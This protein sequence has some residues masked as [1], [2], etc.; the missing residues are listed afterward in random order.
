VDG[1]A[2]LDLFVPVYPG[3]GPGNFFLYNLGPTGPGEAYRFAE[4]S[5]D[6]GLDIPSGNERPEGA[7]AADVDFD[8]DVDLYSNGTLYQNASSPGNPKFNTLTGSASGITLGAS[9]D[10]GCMF[11]DYDLDGDQDLGVAYINEGARIWENRG[12]G[13]FVATE[14]GIIDDPLSGRNLGMSAEDWDN[15]RDIDFTTREVFR[16]NMLV[17]EGARHFTVATHSIPANHINSATPAWGDWDLDGD[18]DCAMGNWGSDGHLYE[19][20]L[21][22]PSTPDSEKRHVR[23]RVVRNSSL[24]SRGLETEYGAAAEIRIRNVQ[25]GFRHRKF[26]ASSHGY[27]NQNEYTLHFALPPD[28]TPDDP[29]EDVRFA[30]GVDFPGASSDG[31]WRVDG[32]V[33]P[34]LSELDLASLADREITVYRCGQV[35]V[36][37]TVHDPL[38]LA[39]PT[40]TTTTGGLAVVDASSP[41]PDPVV[42]PQP[43]FYVGLALDTLGA[44][45][46]VRVEEILLDGQL[47]QDG[48]PCRPVSFT[49]ALWDVTDPSNP[50]VVPAG[51]LEDATSPRN[52]RS[53]FPSDIVLAPGRSFRIVA[54]VSE[55]RATTIEAPV[56]HG[57]VNVQGGLFFPDAAPCTGQGVAGAEPDPGGTALAIRFRAVPDGDPVDPV[58]S[59]LRIDRDGLSPALRWQD[60]G[61]GAYSILRCVANGPCTPLPHATS[62]TSTYLD[63]DAGETGGSYWYLVRAVNGCTAG[64]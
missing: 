45:G 40:L 37:G 58:G 50:V 3:L 31:Q 18:L 55:Y 13:T 26:V 25:D 62:A 22:G 39:P 51:A 4:L 14:P 1:D 48:P 41:L 5:G 8:G 15:D 21:Y 63:H 35:I 10:E 12:D 42:A 54:R 2:N 30:L 6:A 38:P 29:T 28:P 64:L 9:R 34:V 17:E 46:D 60:V 43:D 32:H 23:V 44:T 7:Q 11:L 59:S 61:A 36:N 53:Y 24:A 57:P 33:N 16:R 20:T 56:P 47:A 27:L 49:I 52:R 19:S